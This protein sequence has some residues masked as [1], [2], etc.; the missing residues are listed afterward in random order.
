ML[1]SFTLYCFTFTR[2]VVG[3]IGKLAEGVKIKNQGLSQRKER[4]QQP[5]NS[6]DKQ[7]EVLLVRIS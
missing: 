3:I 6:C 5:V 2:E 1:Y 7:I 4:A